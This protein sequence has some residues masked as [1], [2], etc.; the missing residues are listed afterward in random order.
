MEIDTTRPVVFLDFDGV[1]NGGWQH[2]YLSIIDPS[3]VMRRDKFGDWVCRSKA[4]AL[5]GIFR[6]HKAQVIIVS[7]WCRPYQRHD[8]EE[9]Q[10]LRKFFDY[11][12]IWGSLSTGGGVE[13]PR[14]IWEF[15]DTYQDI[16]NW[17][18]IDDSYHL[19]QEPLYEEE[20]DI[21]FD[22]SRL[23]A[24]NGRYGIADCQLA[25]VDDLL[26]TN[27]RRKSRYKDTLTFDPMNHSR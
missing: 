24:C 22:T 4:K 16:H 23:I 11:P 27:K 15:L 19:Y 10:T 25:E 7:S 2:E 9:I 26:R 12:D 21:R 5:F 8:S 20:D 1:L 14:S 17:V 18:A 6:I 3:D 13:R